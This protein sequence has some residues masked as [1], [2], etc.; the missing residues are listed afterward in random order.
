MNTMMCMYSR[1]STQNG[2]QL[3]EFA[4][5]LFLNVFVHNMTNVFSNEVGPFLASGFLSSV[6]SKKED[7]K[8]S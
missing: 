8:K 5:M 6:M 7:S 4:L 1:I 3:W 2:L